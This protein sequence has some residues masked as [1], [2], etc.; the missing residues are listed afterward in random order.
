M[1][2]LPRTNFV[3]VFLIFSLDQKFALAQPANN[4]YSDLVVASDKNDGQEIGRLIEEGETLWDTNPTPYLNYEIAAATKLKNLYPMA[5]LVAFNNVMGKKSPQ[6][7]I[8]A[9]NYFLKKRIFILRCFSCGLIS[10]NQSRLLQVAQFVGEAR[11]KMIPGYIIPPKER[12]EIENQM[13]WYI[14]GVHP[15]IPKLSPTI[16]SLETN[17]PDLLINA[18]NTLQLLLID[19]DKSITPLLINFVSRVPLKSP[20]DSDFIEEISDAARL[21]GEE[22]EKLKGL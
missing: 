1:K 5:S 11:T 13:G 10:S 2:I 8:G 7:I 6:N 16:P 18:T 19:T 22:R 3:L 9:S 12:A 21:T 14:N 17:T 4:L 15:I 20:T